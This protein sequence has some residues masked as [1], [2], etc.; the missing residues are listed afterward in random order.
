MSSLPSPYLTPE[1]YLELER[2]AEQKSEY[3]AGE[4]FA[5]SGGTMNHAQIAA[6]LIA[7][8]ARQLDDGPCRAIGSDL[9]VLVDATGL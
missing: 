9:R 7:Q 8:F 2:R 6:N 4:M 3:Y 5:M 1:E